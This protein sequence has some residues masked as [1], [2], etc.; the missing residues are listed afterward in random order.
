MALREGVDGEWGGG[1]GE[2]FEVVKPSDESV[3]GEEVDVS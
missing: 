2:S 3:E 1:V